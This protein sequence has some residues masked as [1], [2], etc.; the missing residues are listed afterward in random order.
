MIDQPGLIEA[1][2]FELCGPRLVEAVRYDEIYRVVIL[3]A[4]IIDLH[5]S[6]SVFG[7]T[8]SVAFTRALGH[9]ENTVQV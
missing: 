6:A 8:L 1:V 3:E 9:S 7:T 2:G 5:D 4:A